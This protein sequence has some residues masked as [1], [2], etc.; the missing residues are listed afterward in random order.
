MHTVERRAFSKDEVTPLFLKLR[1][2]ILAG[3]WGALDRD[4]LA[5]LKPSRVVISHGTDSR[6]LEYILVTHGQVFDKKYFKIVVQ[7]DPVPRYKGTNTTNW[8]VLFWINK[9]R[10][11]YQHR[12]EIMSRFKRDLEM[13]KV[14]RFS[15]EED[16]QM[17]SYI[18]RFQATNIDEVERMVNQLLPALVKAI[19]PT[20]SSVISAFSTD[21]PEHDRR[22][23]INNTL[24]PT[25]LNRLGRSF[26]IDTRF[27]HAV[28]KAMRIEVFQRDGGKCKLCDNNITLRRFHA[29]HIIPHSKG[30][31]TILSNLQS[32]CAAC[33][34]R[35]GNRLT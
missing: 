33:N 20:Y 21:V 10:G 1:H 24:R 22:K 13:L 5:A 23:M 9:I 34:Y 8:A 19:Y 3:T 27:G 32:L 16:K 30:G 25:G 2:E 14:P 35:K 18:S 4:L 7:H 29:D 26:G 31:L 11:A 6:V 28:P 12:V 15:F 17:L